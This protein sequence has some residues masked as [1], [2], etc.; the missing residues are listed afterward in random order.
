MDKQN[1]K[2]LINIGIVAV[3]YF[4]IIRPILQKIGISKTQEER[5][6]EEAIK[7]ATTGGRKTNPWDPNFYNVPGALLIRMADAIQ[8]ADRIYNCSAPN[9]FYQDDEGCITGQI[10][11]L[12][13]QSQVSFLAK[14]FQD[15]YKT[16]LLLFLQK[17]RTSAP[18]AGLSDSELA[19][20]LQNVANKPKYKI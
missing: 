8:R 2:L 12:K 5:E 1:Q 14:V 7:T 6:G 16:N 15:K 4:G 17:G 9:Y 18:W 19:A 11:S 13:T 3:A 20:V 10:T